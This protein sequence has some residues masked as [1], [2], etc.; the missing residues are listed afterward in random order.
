M[1]NDLVEQA[2]KLGGVANGWQGHIVVRVPAQG[3]TDRFWHIAFYFNSWDEL[4]ELLK[5]CKEKGF[6]PDTDV[7]N[8]RVSNAQK[9]E[10]LQ[11]PGPGCPHHGVESLRKSRKQ[12]WLFCS[13]RMPNGSYCKHT[14]PE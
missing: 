1:A 13:A 14:E 10:V 9:T 6:E 5:R 7:I 4:G 11:E 2:V 8:L 3:Y 12:G